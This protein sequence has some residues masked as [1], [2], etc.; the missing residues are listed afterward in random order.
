[1]DVP[2]AGIH[3]VM[4]SMREDGQCFDRFILTTNK[5]FAKPEDVGPAATPAKAGKLPEPIAAK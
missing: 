3:T 5:E 1:L 2:S 4:F